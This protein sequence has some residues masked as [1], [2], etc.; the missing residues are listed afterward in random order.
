[1]SENA[2]DEDEGP[3]G[4]LKALM[5]QIDDAVYKA[6]QKPR[7]IALQRLR[8]YMLAVLGN[9]ELQTGAELGGALRESPR[10]PGFSSYPPQISKAL[11]D[12]VN[13]LEAE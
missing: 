3:R 5:E 2:E 13:E 6:D 1:M 7:T 10:P 12:A 8:A 11:R 9:E 4:V